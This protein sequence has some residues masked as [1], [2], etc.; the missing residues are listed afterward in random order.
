M[1]HPLTI[2]QL[3]H[4]TGVPAKTI[5][6]YEQ[7]GILPAPRRTTAGYR[8][9]AQG[10][11]HRLLFIR[12]ARALGLSLRSIQTL[13]AALDSGQRLSMRPRLQHLLTEHLDTVRRQIADFQLLERQLE[14]V[15]QRLQTIS[16]LEDAEDCRCLESQATPT[17]QWIS[18]Q[19]P[20]H[21]T[22]GANMSPHD[23]M[24]SLTRLAMTS[25]G[26]CG[27]GCGCGD[28]LSLIHLGL[29]QPVAASAGEEALRPREDRAGRAARGDTLRKGR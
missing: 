16:S 25:D 2:G 15:L 23:T 5:R 19:P 4:A 26:N 22:E 29:P 12:R 10:D 7:V 24:E 6:Y 3:A 8:Q 27:C 11:M 18:Q 21:T 17:A 1:E 13:T 28:G 20:T 9:Y 14:Q